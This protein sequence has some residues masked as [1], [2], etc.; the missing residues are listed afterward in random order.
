MQPFT[1]T[2][3]VQF[4]FE[5]EADL[6]SSFDYYIPHEFIEIAVDQT[7]LYAQQEIS[8]MPRRITKHSRSEAL[9]Q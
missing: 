9:N 6:M 4:G 2:E 7:N 3:G 8:K 5:N 1:G